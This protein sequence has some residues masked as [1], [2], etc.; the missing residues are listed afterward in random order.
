MKY[1][2]P[3]VDR[4]FRDSGAWSFFF[5]ERREKSNCM[6][7]C[8]SFCVCV[9]FKY[10]QFSRFLGC[11]TFYT[12]GNDKTINDCFTCAIG[13]Y[14]S[15]LYQLFYPMSRYWDSY[16]AVSLCYITQCFD[17]LWPV[18][19]KN[20]KVT[21]LRTDHQAAPNYPKDWKLT[22]TIKKE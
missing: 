3:S 2:T 1:V 7:T 6:K 12:Q 14:C 21:D 19:P 8:F 11:L 22:P 9:C 13:C 10:L 17:Y 16:N 20:C 15:P 4:H 18:S 5:H